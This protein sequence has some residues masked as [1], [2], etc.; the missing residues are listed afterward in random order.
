VYLFIR[1]IRAES[2]GRAE[3]NGNEEG[4]S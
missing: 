1:P 4:K 2:H 3:T